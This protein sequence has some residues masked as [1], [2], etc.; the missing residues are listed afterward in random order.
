M[1]TVDGGHREGPSVCVCGVRFF[2][3]RAGK[4]AATPTL[5][6]PPAYLLP[7]PPSRPPDA[8][9]IAAASCVVDM[10]V[11]HRRIGEECLEQLAAGRSP[12]RRRRSSCRPRH[13]RGPTGDG[14]RRPVGVRLPVE[15][16][17][18]ATDVDRARGAIGRM[19]AMVRK[20]EQ[21]DPLAGRGILERD[22]ARAR[23]SA[24]RSAHGACCARPDRRRPARRG[25]ANC[26]ASRPRIRKDMGH[27]RL[28]TGGPLAPAR[29]RKRPGSCF[30]AIAFA[31]DGATAGGMALA[32]TGATVS[33]W[34]TP[35]CPID[36]L[37]QS[38][39]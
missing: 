27:S 31:P 20:R 18:A 25:A 2:Q 9:R 17:A 3:W 22:A 4:V 8:A 6:C 16:A 14:R 39:S 19:C 11:V 24:R 28:D 15:R 21:D 5:L 38:P 30:K 7:A 29:S 12:P 13:R 34:D 32:T 1:L 26:V 37:S 36:R 23:C 10:Q 33:L 35:P